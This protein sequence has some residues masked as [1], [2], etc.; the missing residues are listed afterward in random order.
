MFSGNSRKI[1]T[2]AIVLAIFF[3]AC[4][5]WQKTETAA[6]TPAT[7]FETS[8]ELPF[9]TTEPENYQ[10]EIVTRIYANGEKNEFK[11]FTARSGNRRLTIFNVGEKTEIS[12]LNLNDGAPLS[13]SEPKK[14]YTENRLTATDF[15]NP[16]DDFLTIEW[17][18][19]KA[20]AAFEKMATE[21]NITKFRVRLNDS[22]NSESLI[23]FDENLKIPVRQEFYKIDGGQKTL[24]YS[25]EV[26]NFK[27]ETDENLF[28]PPKD[29]RKVSAKEFQEILWERIRN[30]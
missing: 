18:N 1:L 9:S 15:V 29:F 2:A 3:P 23:Y 21:N 7:I 16:T 11:I 27:A 12:S 4:R 28:A 30:K 6:P 26:K 17:I 5:F 22:E 19:A 20:A 8:R 13:I 14:I 10:A 24:T 25:V